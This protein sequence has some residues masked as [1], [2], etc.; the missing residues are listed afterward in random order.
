M[1]ETILIATLILLAF[2]F[3][4]LTGLIIGATLS[5]TAVFI[6]AAVLAGITVALIILAL[7]RQQ[8]S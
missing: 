7:W 8:Q 1:R 5:P 4:G 6:G 3:S 2:M